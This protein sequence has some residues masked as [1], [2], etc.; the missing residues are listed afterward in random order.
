MINNMTAVQIGGQEYTAPVRGDSVEVSGYFGRFTSFGLAG[1]QSLVVSF[2]NE[3]CALGVAAR[4][5]STT[6]L[7]P[8]VMGRHVE[9][10]VEACDWSTRRTMN[11]PVGTWLVARGQAADVIPIVRH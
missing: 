8:Q 1:E 2:D 10:P 6:G 9:L 7:R 4:I 5:E 11:S 3:A